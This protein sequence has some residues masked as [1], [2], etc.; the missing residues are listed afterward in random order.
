MNSEGQSF[1]SIEEGLEEKDV[2]VVVVIPND[3]LRCA[4]WS[5]LPIT[6][7]S[8]HGQNL[9]QAGRRI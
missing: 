7:A 1:V 8:H 2:F 5:P 6:V 9:I 4:D 3:Q